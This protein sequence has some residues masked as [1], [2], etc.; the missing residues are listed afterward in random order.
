MLHKSKIQLNTVITTSLFAKLRLQ[1]RIFYGTNYFLTVNLNIIV[2]G[3]NNTCL[4][5]HNIRSIS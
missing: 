2:L 3:Y 1:H 5:R 4:Q